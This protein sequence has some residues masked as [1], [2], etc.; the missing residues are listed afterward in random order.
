V[1]HVGC[2]SIPRIYSHLKLIQL[3][4][5]HRTDVALHRRDKQLEKEYITNLQQQVYFL[6]M[7]LTMMKK[8]AVPKAKGLDILPDA[9]LDKVIFTLREKYDTMESHYK[10]NLREK[11]ENILQLQEDLEN[12]QKSYALATKK[13]QD[14]IER[15]KKALSIAAQLKQ[16][17]FYQNSSGNLPTENNPEM[18][19][20]SPD[21]I[22]QGEELKLAQF[23]RETAQVLGLQPSSAVGKRNGRRARPSRPQT[24]RDATRPGETSGGN[25]LF[26]TS[27]AFEDSEHG[28]KQPSEEEAA[29]A[30][31][32]EGV[33]VGVGND[34]LDL[35]SLLGLSMQKV[36]ELEGKVRELMEKQH[37]EDASHKSKIQDRDNAYVEEVKALKHELIVLD[38][39]R[40]K[41]ERDRDYFASKAQEDEK[42]RVELENALRRD[43]KH[44][45]LVAMKQEQEELKR[46]AEN[47]LRERANAQYELHMWKQR[48][49]AD[50]NNLHQV[51]LQNELLT[52]DNERLSAENFELQSL[53]VKIQELEQKLQN[54]EIEMDRLHQDLR[55][56]ANREGSAAETVWGL[57]NEINNLRADR[58]E[59][60]EAKRI[61]D[62]QVN[63][64]NDKMH[65][66]RAKNI[67]LSE[68]L[69][70]MRSEYDALLEKYRKSEKLMEL[71][72][73]KARAAMKDRDLLRV[74]CELDPREMRLLSEGAASQLA[75][76]GKMYRELGGDAPSESGFPR[77]E[78]R[79]ERPPREN[80]PSEVTDQMA[81]S[82]YARNN[83]MKPIQQSF[84]MSPSPGISGNP[85]QRMPY[86]LSNLSSSSAV[87][88]SASLSRAVSTPSQVDQFGHSPVSRSPKHDEYPATDQENMALMET[89]PSRNPEQLFMNS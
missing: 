62:E 54:K 42:K 38:N 53:P 68:E 66:V 33:V 75:K 6:E 34:P 59:W 50:L 51:Q 5:P 67:V 7:E 27:T 20:T 63:D 10:R 76:V 11:Q 44:G 40:A 57:E 23:V 87:P 39:A 36:R 60:L 81:Y 37:A 73:A 24:Q 14:Q 8:A 84:N 83:S 70:R 69:E 64:I 15:R 52:R 25:E 55:D 56:A 79:R 4:S 9:P 26:Y 19:T 16:D 47:A 2:P 1:H 12:S 85:Y 89:L 46:I 49:E 78:S 29:D 30:V 17:G 45:P 28:D 82:A 88:L 22:E 31:D 32:G 71:A 48:Y 13:L 41:A 58:D 77:E 80:F 43:D 65:R 74:L 21:S 61:Q 18:S 3:L 35:L 72:E 86:Q